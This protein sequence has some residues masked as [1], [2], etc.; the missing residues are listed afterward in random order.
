[1]DKDRDIE[2]D[3]W[4]RVSKAADAADADICDM[5]GAF[6][7]ESSPV[8]NCTDRVL[9]AK[10]PVPVGSMTGTS[11][12]DLFWEGTSD[13]AGDRT[14]VV[15]IVVDV[16]GEHTLCILLNSKFWVKACSSMILTGTQ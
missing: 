9:A 1:M 13:H 6:A 2:G 4:G 12:V 7:T 10:L 16:R 8:D 15:E 11:K 14:D 3:S 5:R